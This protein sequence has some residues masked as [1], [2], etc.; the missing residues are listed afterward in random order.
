[1]ES[2]QTIKAMLISESRLFR[3]GMKQLLGGSAYRISVEAKGPEDAFGNLQS[4][5]GAQ[6]VLLDIGAARKDVIEHIRKLREAMP[7]APLVVLG[8][9][10]AIVKLAQTLGS[11][12]NGYVLKDTSPDALVQLLNLIMLGERVFPSCLVQTLIEGRTG[13][14]GSV[15]AASGTGLSEREIEILRYLVS[16]AGNKSIAN[17]LS[18]AESTVK[19]H[20]K[21]ILRKIRRKNRT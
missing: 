19:V 15:P 9:D 10:T 20:M 3:E 4:G 5:P 18:I 21:A 6:L 16:G 8:D 2:L 11:N 7:Q 14:D 1:M 17:H 12:V 13:I